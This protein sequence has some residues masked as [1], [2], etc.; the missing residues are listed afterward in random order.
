MTRGERGRQHTKSPFQPPTDVELAYTLKL[1]RKRVHELLAL[2]RREGAL[3]RVSEALH[4]DA[5]SLAELE[6]KLL[7]TFEQQESIT[8]A[9]LKALAG[10]TSR[11]WAIPLLEYFDRAR[12]TLRAGDVRK[13]HPSRRKL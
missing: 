9:D 7:A 10:G 3:I 12:V 4:F 11:K 5:A 13:L 8:A 2:L 6:Q 1:D